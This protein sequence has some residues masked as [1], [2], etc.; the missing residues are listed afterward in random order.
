[1]N[2]LAVCLMG[3]TATG[4]TDVAVA[5]AE[6]YPCDIISVDSALVYRYMN[7]GTAKPDAET[8]RKAPHQL[9]D[10]RDPEQAYSAGDF[11]RDANDAIQASFAASR[12]PLLVGGTMMYFR[13]LTK[14]IASLPSG[15]PQV[16]RK[17]DREAD[18]S[19]WP[20][21]HEQLMKIDPVAANRIKPTDSQ[22]IQRALEVFEVSGRSLSDWHAA[23]DSPAADSA[24]SYLKVALDV[25]DRSE[26]HARIEQRLD[27]MFN[28][29]LVEEVAGLMQRDGLTRDM[30][31][32]RSVGY[33]QVWSHLVGEV[34]LEES[35]YRALVATRQLA[36]RQ[37]TWLRS[38][39]DL[40][41]VNALEPGKV[42]SISEFL[43]R[44]HPILG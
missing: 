36:K 30:P 7:I 2:N 17:I 14:G 26:L 20:A 33:R 24:S 21:M 39:S 5:L 31:S 43:E 44:N 38:E 23:S 25:A 37:F 41:S 19:G 1:M 10:I 9:V 28:S 22:R 15:D 35:R 40:F 34:T 16:R 27:L 32:M 6:K 42:G 18:A 8:L 3:P 4:K 11:V 12:I 13:A 29:G